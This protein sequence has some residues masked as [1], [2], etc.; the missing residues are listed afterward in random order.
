MGWIMTGKAMHNNSGE[1]LPFVP[2]LRKDKFHVWISKWHW[3][4]MGALALGIFAI[5]RWSCLL[6]GFF[7]VPSLVSTPLGW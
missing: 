3:V 5:G 6:W 4:P 1:L 2:D 7:S